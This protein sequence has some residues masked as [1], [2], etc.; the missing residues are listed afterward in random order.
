LTVSDEQKHLSEEALKTLAFAFQKDEFGQFYPVDREALKVVIDDVTDE[1]LPELMFNAAVQGNLPLMHALHEF[2]GQIPVVYECLDE[3]SET[4]NGQPFYS[5]REKVLG[6]CATSAELKELFT[7]IKAYGLKGLI[8]PGPTIPFIFQEADFS[9]ATEASMASAFEGD[10]PFLDAGILKSPELA[11]SLAD[12]A[13]KSAAPSAYK[14]LLCWATEDMVSLFSDELLAL[15]PIQNVEYEEQSL[16]LVSAG[17][18]FSSLKLE[19]V[20]VFKAKDRPATE[21]KIDRISLGY[22]DSLSHLVST[23][24][25]YMGDPRIRLGFADPKGRVLCET[26]TDFLLAFPAGASTKKNLQASQAFAQDYFPLQIISNQALRSCN[27]DFDLEIIQPGVNYPGIPNGRAAC[28]KYATFIAHRLLEHFSDASPVR[29][30]MLD[31]LTSQQWAD[32]IARAD[33]RYFKASH[34]CILRDVFSINNQGL[35]LELTLK[36]LSALHV[37]NY[38]FAEGTRLFDD[39]TKVFEDMGENPGA[40][41]LL[42]DLTADSIKAFVGEYSHSTVLPEARKLHR[43][44]QSMNLWSSVEKRPEGIRQALEQVVDLSVDDEDDLQGMAISVYL[45][46]QGIAACV[47]EATTVEHWLGIAK[48]FSAEQVQPYLSVM[49]GKARGRVLENQMGL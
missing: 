43:Q 18:R 47:R 29:E 2:R 30:Q 39:N 22:D 6:Y 27:D 3:G 24:D 42:M 26:N 8:E 44:A 36:D 13:M 21:V 31:L 17:V 40:S 23:L 1:E 35:R 34:L 16:Q 11:L 48:C 19:P 41:S 14:P 5:Q 20:G 49:P 32:F 4:L 46:T 28:I 38:Q 12:E 25:H 7:A 37:A 10:L 15:R 33:A 45:E 9:D